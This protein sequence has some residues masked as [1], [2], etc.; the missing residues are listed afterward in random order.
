MTPPNSLPSSYIDY[1]PAVFHDDPFLGQFLL[2]F[3]AILSG[4]STGK[5]KDKFAKGLDQ[6][7]DDIHTYVAP[8]DAPT[9]FLPWLAG[10]VALSLRDDWEEK[11]KR[12]FIQQIIPLYKKRGTAAGLKAM[13]RIYLQ[14]EIKRETDGKTEYV[15]IFEFEAIPHYFQVQLRLDTQ[16]QAEFHRKQTVAR[17]IIE[18]EKPAHTVY[19]LQILMPTMQ[20]FASNEARRREGKESLPGDQRLRLFAG[21]NTKFKEAREQHKNTTLIGN[22]AVRR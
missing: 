10:W 2:A 11:V 5:E 12:D 21:K 13:L 20:L 15:E 4:D 14:K 6:Q 8:Q 19:A 16:N 3:E 7:V 22:T 1:L 18:Q 17:A 9:D